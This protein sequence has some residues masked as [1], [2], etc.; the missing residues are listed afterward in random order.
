MQL[1]QLDNLPA[2]M[3]LSIQEGA[4]SLQEAQELYLLHV[5]NQAGACLPTPEH[6]MPALSR[7]GLWMWPVP[8]PRW[9]H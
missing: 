9:I 8:E 7:L 5:M 2:L 3:S 6:L 4:I 1:L